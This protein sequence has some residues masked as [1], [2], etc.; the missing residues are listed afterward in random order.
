[1]IDWYNLAMNTFWIVGCAV[2][3]ATLSYAS[4]EASA[5]EQKFGE[6][7]GK[8]NIQI[9]LNLAG[10][11]FCIGLAGTSDVIWQ[12]VVWALLGVGFVVQIIW[13]FRKQKEEQEVSMSVQAIIKAYEYRKDQIQKMT[14][15]EFR[16]YQKFNW[17]G[18]FCGSYHSMQVGSDADYCEYMRRKVG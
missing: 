7:L 1:M 12:Q 17:Y 16:D 18:L 14:E 13:E 3:L 6:S 4:W 9:V 8:P 5:S 10:L 2:A 11:L 15:D